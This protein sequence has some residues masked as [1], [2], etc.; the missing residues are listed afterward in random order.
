M[1]RLIIGIV[2]SCFFVPD[3]Q[4]TTLEEEIV[5]NLDQVEEQ[6]FFTIS[7]ENDMLASGNDRNYTSGVRFTSANLSSS[8]ARWE[9]QGLSWIPGFNI[10]PTTSSY[11]SFGQN[12]YTPED[13]SRDPPDPKDRPYAAFA[14]GALGYS[15]V[16]DNHVDSVEFSLGIVGPAA[17]GRQTQKTV[18]E[19]VDSDDPKG[20]DAQLENE[21][22]VILSWERRWPGVRSTRLGPIYLRRIPHAGL[23]LGNVYTYA[24][25]GFMFQLLPNNTRLQSTPVRVRPSIPGNGFFITPEKSFGWM[26]FGGI[27]GRAVAQNIFLD[28]NTW[29]DSAS[30]EKRHWVGDANIGL[31]LLVDSIRLSY[32]VVWRTKEFEQQEN[33]DVFGSLSINYRF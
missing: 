28:G 9:K 13:I 29:R 10:N 7:V 2:A 25:A 26:I 23:T 12:L 22:G 18:H 19:W 20:W 3:A 31:S 11:I 30:V 27:Q 21:P 14:Y 16:S 5:K 15:T 24:N 33:S 1:N 17:L 6:R 8:L 32:T 4:A